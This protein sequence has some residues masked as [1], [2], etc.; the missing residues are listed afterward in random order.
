MK[1]RLPLTLLFSFLIHIGAIHAATRDEALIA[2]VEGGDIAAVA[3]LISSGAEVDQPDAEGLTPLAHASLID[4][5]TIAELLAASGAKSWQNDPS[6]SPL[7]ISIISGS[8]SVLDV[9]LSNDLPAGVFNSAMEL[10]AATG[11]TA[12]IEPFFLKLNIN[13]SVDAKSRLRFPLASEKAD[14]LPVL[15][16]E[17]LRLCKTESRFD[18]EVCVK[19]DR[20]QKVLTAVKKPIKPKALASKDGVDSSG[21]P[22]KLTAHCDFT[23]TAPKGTKLTQPNFYMGYSWISKEY[24]GDNE[25]FDGFMLYAGGPKMTSYSVDENFAKFSLAADYKGS[26]WTGDFVSDL[27]TGRFTA[28]MIFK[29]KGAN[30]TPVKGAGKCKIAE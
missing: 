17:T 24:Y 2:A 18:K 20:I 23:A 19:Q 4:R 22:M 28:T 21:R 3:A 29:N 5:A 25:Y 8:A 6:L 9:L 27:E 12:V 15:T 30:S 7:H 13:L 11:N 16:I 26:K 10:A 14:L 1:V